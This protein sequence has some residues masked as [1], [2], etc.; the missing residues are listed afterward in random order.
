MTGGLP[1]TQNRREPRSGL[2][3]LID[4]R[5]EPTCWPIWD[6]SSGC[7]SSF[8]FFFFFFKALAGQIGLL[9][10]VLQAPKL[11]EH[12]RKKKKM[13]PARLSYHA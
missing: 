13:V 1:L 9:G 7:Y 3:L 2:L 4:S 11:S 12:L 8:F 10:E 5:C 6:F